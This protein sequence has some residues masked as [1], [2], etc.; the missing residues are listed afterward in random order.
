M[1]TYSVVPNFPINKK[2]VIDTKFK[3]KKEIIHLLFLKHS[4]CT[5]ANFFEK[6]E[7]VLMLKKILKI[8]RSHK[9]RKK[10]GKSNMNIKFIWIFYKLLIITVAK[11]V[12]NIDRWYIAMIVHTILHTFELQLWY[13]FRHFWTNS[14]RPDAGHLWRRNYQFLKWHHLFA[15]YWLLEIQNLPV[16]KLVLVGHTL[17][18]LRIWIKILN[19]IQR[20]FGNWKYI[21]YDHLE[22]SINY[23]F[24]KSKIINT[25][26]KTNIR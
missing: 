4:M 14:G 1:S 5:I 8:F 13:L 12:Y 26:S 20:C 15:V 22:L 9:H 16:K 18:H 23:S 17:L 21:N 2:H 10:I 24:A 3:H 19:I 6:N 7:T 11:L 25:C